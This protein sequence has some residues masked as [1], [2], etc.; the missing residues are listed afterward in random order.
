MIL[1][2][3]TLLLQILKLKQTDFDVTAFTNNS[4]R[5]YTFHS[6]SLV[7]CLYRLINLKFFHLN[8]QLM[9]PALTY[10]ITTS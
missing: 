10:K 5:H 8:I 9:H 7:Q 1:I 6:H 3:N 2:G 4:N